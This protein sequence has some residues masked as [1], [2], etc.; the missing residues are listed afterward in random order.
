LG[1][2]VS[3]SMMDD[4]GA[5]RPWTGMTGDILGGHDVPV[6]SYGPDGVDVVTW[7]TL[8]HISWE[9]MADNQFL[10]EAH[11]E[12]FPDFLNAAGSAPSG[13]NLQQLLA[14][15]QLLQTSP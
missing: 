5:A 11:C 12:L 15:L 10:E 7:G 3:Q 6:V 14:D 8:Q 1:I 2:V 13:F 9:L 4:F